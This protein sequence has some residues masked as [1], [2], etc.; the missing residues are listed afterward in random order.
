[1]KVNVAKTNLQRALNAV[2]KAVSS[3]PTIEVLANIAL[4][5]RDGTLKLAATDLE[6]SITILIGAEVLEEG[7]TTVSAKTFVSFVSLLPDTNVLLTL[8]DNELKVNANKINSKFSTIPYDEFPAITQVDDSCVLILEIDKQTFAQAV[9]KVIFSVD[10]VGTAQ[11]VFSG[12]LLE[13]DEGNI[14]FV[15]TDR[16]RLSRYTLTVDK[17]KTSLNSS[18]FILIPYYALENAARLSTDN[19]DEIIEVHLT[20]KNSQI[21]F[22]NGQLEIVSSLIEGEFPNYKA[23]IPKEKVAA[24][25]LKT[26]ELQEVVR[27]ANVFGN[28]K[29]ESSLGIAFKKE[30]GSKELSVSASIAE[31][32]GYDTA[33]EVET[34]VDNEDID[35]YFNHKNIL[36]A[37]N[38]INTEYLILEYAIHP[39]TQYRVLMIKEDN[40]DNYFHLLTPLVRV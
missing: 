2:N 19:N 37:I 13:Y 26:K 11:P 40:N 6:T 38:H 34:I 36:E 8:Q 16:T 1:M 30:R 39:P 18:R 21:I 10:K 27:L 35:S 12:V 29:T 4:E 17:I 15:A 9:D 31:V 25:R 3:K 28:V 7:A 14:N 20:P 32:G 33:I 22:R 5:A 23:F 24:Y